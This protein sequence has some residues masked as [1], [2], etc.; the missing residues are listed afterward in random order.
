MKHILSLLVALCASTHAQTLYTVTDL[1]TLGGPT[2]FAL[3][4]NASGVV[5]GQADFGVSSK[6]HPAFTAFIFRNG[7]MQAIDPGQVSSG[8]AINSRGEA[9]GGNFLYRDGVITYPGQPDSLSFAGINNSGVIVGGIVVPVT[10]TSGAFNAMLYRNGVVTNLGTL[11]GPNSYATGINNEGQVV[12]W[13][14]LASD[15]NN[16]HAFLWQNGHMFDIGTLAPAS[17]AL[18]YYSQAN[19]INDHGQIVGYSLTTSGLIDAFL[20]QNGVMKDLGV[21][22]GINDPNRSIFASAINNRGEIVGDSQN[23]SGA[24]SFAPEI[25]FLYTGGQMYNLN[26]LLV[27]SDSGWVIAYANGIN[28]AGQIAATGTLNNGAAH[29]V[30]LD[31]IHLPTAILP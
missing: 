25:A 19:A 29:A 20:W 28:D 8:Q 3:A 11:G 21:V 6:G 30:R 7:K 16:F 2:S 23:S 24:E 9:V 5:T 15:Y 12:G 17:D 1:G 27:P 26:S 31:P 22:P 10:G 14:T 4:I 18:N 13:Y